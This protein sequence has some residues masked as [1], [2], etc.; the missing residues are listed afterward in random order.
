MGKTP[1]A[2]RIKNADDM[3]GIPKKFVG[4]AIGSERFLLVVSS[5][6]GYLALDMAHDASTTVDGM[7]LFDSVTVTDNEQTPPQAAGYRSFSSGIAFGV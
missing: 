7:F 2:N 3:L 1:G 4:E 6:G 5:Y